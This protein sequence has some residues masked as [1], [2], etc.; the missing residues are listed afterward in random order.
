MLRSALNPGFGIW[1][2][3]WHPAIKVKFGIQLYVYVEYFCPTVEMLFLRQTAQKY[4]G[5]TK[6]SN[7]YSQYILVLGFQVNTVYKKI[8]R[9]LGP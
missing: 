3:V 9:N 1:D 8:I 5:Q 2:L 4:H 7:M 6:V